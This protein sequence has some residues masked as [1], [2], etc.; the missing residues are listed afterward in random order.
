MQTRPCRVIPLVLIGAAC[1]GAEPFPRIEGE[2]LAGK[3]IVLPE[4]AAGR[5]AVLVLGFTHASQTQ[6][7]AWAERLHREFNDPATVAVYSIAVLEDV[8]RLVRGMAVHGIRSGVPQDQRETFLLVYH[9]EKVLKQAAGFDQPDDAY[10]L[11]LNRRGD[12]LW[13]FHGAVTDRAVETL[14]AQVRGE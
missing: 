14:T 12:V 8:P 9:N 7:K 10:V 5:T 2:S 3:S 6:T 11:A 4:A 13:R 1:F